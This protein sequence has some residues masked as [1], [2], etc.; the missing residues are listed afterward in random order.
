MNVSTTVTAHATIIKTVLAKNLEF[1]NP[2]LLPYFIL[3]FTMVT[4][5]AMILTT[6]PVKILTI[7]HLLNIMTVS[8]SEIA[9]ASKEEIALARI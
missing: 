3:V 9:R 1:V 2:L 5:H 8:I 4:A 6:A 7:A